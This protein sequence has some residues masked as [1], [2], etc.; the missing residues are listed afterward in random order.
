MD[1]ELTVRDLAK[2]Y[3]YQAITSGG[4]NL[5]I[6]FT[7]KSDYTYLQVIFISYIKFFSAI[8]NDIATEDLD[9]L[10]LTERIYQDAYM[11]WRSKRKLKDINDQMTKKVQKQSPSHNKIQREKEVKPFSWNL[12]TK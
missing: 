11:Y 9:E 8:M 10:V 12:K 5:S 2:S 3:R 1:I 7:N 6:L 4:D